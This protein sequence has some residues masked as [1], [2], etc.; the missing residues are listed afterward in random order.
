MFKIRIW[1]KILELNPIWYFDATGSILKKITN[2]NQPL[3]YSIV[4]HDPLNEQIIPI[5]EFHTTSHNDI[6]ISRY[7]IYL[8]KTLE[9]FSAFKSLIPPFIVVDFS[10]ALINSTVDVF[11]KMSVSQYLNLTYELIFNKKNESDISFSVL[12]TRIYLCSSHFLKSAITKA[13]KLSKI[14]DNVIT[15]FI[16]LFSLLQNSTSI[17]QFNLYLKQIYI[18]FHQPK[19]TKLVLISLKKLCNSV[20]KR[21]LSNV[22]YEIDENTDEKELNEESNVIISDVEY[23]NY[24]KESPFSIYFDKLITSFSKLIRNRNQIK[25]KNKFYNPELFKIIKDC[26]HLLPFWTGLLIKEYSDRT[27]KFKEA[28][29]FSNNPVECWFKI[30][31]HS[32]LRKLKVNNYLK[33]ILNC[34][35][36]SRIKFD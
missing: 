27:G 29:R 28:T 35:K 20:L 30:L 7:L 22:I 1:L 8:K 36:N 26:L 17:D 31:K 3:L 23:E 19:E 11:N 2:Q 18:I 13:R 4:C 14:P 15:T 32:I 5:F 33:K 21:K 24:K 9:T 12:K 6:T 10:W 34:Q 16:Y 25:T